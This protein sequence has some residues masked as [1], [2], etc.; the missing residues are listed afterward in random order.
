MQQR[1]EMMLSTHLKAIK[2]IG[3]FH[4]CNYRTVDDLKTTA[5]VSLLVGFTIV[6]KT[7]NLMLCS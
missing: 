2:Q 7:F 6:L 3:Q 5:R 1:E 4:K